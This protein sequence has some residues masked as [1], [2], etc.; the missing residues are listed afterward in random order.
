M[1]VSTT[2][3]R[4]DYTRVLVGNFGL[5][6][7][8]VEK[9]YEY[10]R[11]MNFY[12]NNP[13]T[14]GEMLERFFPGRD[15]VKRLLMEPIAY[16]NGSTLDDPS[17]TYGIVFSNFM[18]SGVYTFRGGSDLLI[19]KM[20]AELKRNGVE[21]RKKVLELNKIGVLSAASIVNEDKADEGAEAENP[22][23]KVKEGLKKAA[24]A[25]P[26]IAAGKRTG[27]KLDA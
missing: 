5:E 14:T 24:E 23:P 16:A 10:L 27:A 9:F 2:F 13:E 17:I 7:T 21:V 3:T 12:D 8:H 25:K 22:T 18:G 15:D 1:D 4:E 26:A 20:I 19:E 11:G 6:R